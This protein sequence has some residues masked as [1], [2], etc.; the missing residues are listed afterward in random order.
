M[1]ELIPFEDVIPEEVI[2]SV[3]FFG[4]RANFSRLRGLVD[5]TS[6]DDAVSVDLVNSGQHWDPE[7]VGEGLGHDAYNLEVHS[8]ELGK[9]MDASVGYLLE[10]KPRFVWVYG[11]TATALGAALAAKGCDIPVGH[12][13]SGF[14]L[15]NAKGEKIITDYPED[16]NRRLIDSIATIL[17]PLTSDEQN[18]LYEEKS[19]GLISGHITEVSGHPLGDRFINHPEQFATT[20]DRQK[21]IVTIHRKLNIHSPGQASGLARVIA[22]LSV[23]QAN[24]VD[25]L[26]PAHPAA[27]KHIQEFGIK[28]PSNV[29]LVSPLPY[30]E[31]MD[32]LA[33]RGV[34][35]TDAAGF[36]LEA[37]LAGRRPAVVREGHDY[38]SLL[39]IVQLVEPEKAAS[40]SVELSESTLGSTELEALRRH[41]SQGDFPGSVLRIMKS[42]IVNDKLQSAH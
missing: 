6:S 13:E 25:W 31:L 24:D 42:S 38:P 35:V 16:K 33:V 28:L 1:P 14:R 17:I 15:Y 29:E 39:D 18:T 4:P 40:S 12:I 3:L 9:L 34:V 10:H 26:F 5:L 21:G 30:E 8:S 27:R 2:P 41:Y 36:M 7:L 23:G 19:Q 11:D 22:G 32:E 20:P 37:A